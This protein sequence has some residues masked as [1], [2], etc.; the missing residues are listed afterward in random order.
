M[1]CS[2]GHDLYGSG[3]GASVVQ[4][5]FCCRALY[6]R[7]HG[8]HCNSPVAAYGSVVL[9]WTHGAAQR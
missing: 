8:N 7:F 2:R 4:N 5:L 6:Q 3:G 9:T 1:P